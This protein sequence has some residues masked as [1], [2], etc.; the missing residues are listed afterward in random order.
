MA[1]TG[2][3][4]GDKEVIARLKKIAQENPSVV[5]KAMYTHA[6]F[7]MTESKKEVPVDTGTARSSGFVE[8]PRISSSSVSVKLGYGGPASK[9]NPKGGEA[10]DYIER[11]HEDTEARHTVGKAKFLED[12]VRR[13]AKKFFND[14]LSSVQKDIQKRGV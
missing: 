2:T 6:E 13:N 10:A 3:V 4:T 8:E 5:A 1:T 12:P 7:L 14:V 11:L 9:Q